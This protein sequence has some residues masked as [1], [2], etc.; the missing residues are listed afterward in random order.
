MFSQ[1]FRK[2]EIDGETVG[3]HS[4]IF[5]QRNRA[6]QMTHR[7]IAVF[8]QMGLARQ[9]DFRHSKKRNDSWP[10]MDRDIIA[11][12][13]R[14]MK[15][16]KDQISIFYVF[17]ILHRKRRRICHIP[18]MVKCINFYTSISYYSMLT[19]EQSTVIKSIQL[20]VFKITHSSRT[21]YRINLQGKRTHNY[22]PTCYDNKVDVSSFPEKNTFRSI[23][24][25]N[26]FVGSITR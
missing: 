6:D 3:Q 21:S 16:E 2:K 4:Y 26:F 25:P 20:H 15:K 13:L 12:Y 14:L 19:E 11:T 18:Y 9:Y 22:S 24:S 7:H 8:G 10:F 17:L 1:T 23:F 5:L